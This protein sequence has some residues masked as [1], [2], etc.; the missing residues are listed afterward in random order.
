MQDAMSLT[1][2]KL[3]SYFKINKKELSVENFRKR[4][5]L[6]GLKL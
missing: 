5:N 4:E 1:N 6:S 2:L 3:E